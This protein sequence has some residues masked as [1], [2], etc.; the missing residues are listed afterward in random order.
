MV[1]KPAKG[2]T[3]M[4][5]AAALFALAVLL[6]A[7]AMETAAINSGNRSDPKASLEQAMK[8]VADRDKTVS[9]IAVERFKQELA[10]V[11]GAPADITGA[12]AT[13]AEGGRSIEGDELS[14]ARDITRR[15]SLNR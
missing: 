5:R 12:G 3:L 6:A 14:V 2:V 9:Q 7:S 13:G 15:M 8:T 10:G 11:S 4:V 1:V